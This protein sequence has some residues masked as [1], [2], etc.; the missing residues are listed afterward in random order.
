M[1]IW[2][3]LLGCLHRPGMCRKYCRQVKLFCRIALKNK[4]LWECFSSM[5]GSERD[6]F[7]GVTYRDDWS[8]SLKRLYYSHRDATDRW[9]SKYLDFCLLSKK[10]SNRFI[11]LH[12]VSLHNTIKAMKKRVRTLSSRVG[13]GGKLDGPRRVLYARCAGSSCSDKIRHHKRENTSCNGISW[14]NQK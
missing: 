13:S 1:I 2:Q 6:T 9:A 7:V 4:S 14:K 5:F 11:N 10:Y 12:N 8:F 3:C